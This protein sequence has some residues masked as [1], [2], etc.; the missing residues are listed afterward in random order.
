MAIQNLRPTLHDSVKISSI[1]D[2]A[3]DLHHTCIVLGLWI[4]NLAN[5]ITG[6]TIKQLH[7]EGHAASASDKSFTHARRH[8]V[9]G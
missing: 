6:L 9:G 5:D 3:R 2:T 1:S 4:D 7:V 8:Q